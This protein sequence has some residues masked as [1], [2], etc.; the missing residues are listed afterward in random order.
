MA[1]MSVVDDVRDGKA[2][3]EWADVISKAANGTQLRICVM[4]D[5][6]KIDGVRVSASANDLQQIADLLGCM[7]LTPKVVDLIWQQAQVRFDPVI[8]ADNN[9]VASSNDQRV[10]GL[11]DEQIAKHGGDQGGLVD[12]IGKYWVLHNHLANPGLKFGKSNAC[13]YGWLSSTGLYAALTPSLKC[14]QQPGFQH[15]DGHRDPSQIIRL[16]SRKAFLTKPG[17]EEQQVDLLDVLR[18]PALAKLANH[19]GVLHYVRLAS[20]PEST[21]DE[22]PAVSTYSG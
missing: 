7:L 15:N 9:I 3:I 11:V 5:G 4:R 10:S 1:R 19:D 17:E 12:S 6:L 21:P 8:R 14:W 13:N 22:P 20:V 2:Q 16:M 18:D